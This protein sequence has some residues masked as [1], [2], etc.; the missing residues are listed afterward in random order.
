MTFSYFY[1]IC[2]HETYIKSA[3]ISTDNMQ[4]ITLYLY[5]LLGSIII[6]KKAIYPIVY[7]EINKSHNQSNHYQVIEKLLNSITI[8][9]E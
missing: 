1:E 6:V 2:E 5:P 9:Q 3:R 7:L 4:S 8:I